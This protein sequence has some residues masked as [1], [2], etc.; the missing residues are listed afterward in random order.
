MMAASLRLGLRTGVTFGVT[1]IFLVL[2]GLNAVLAEMIG[3]LL[4]AKAVPGEGSVAGMVALLALLGLWSGARSAPRL[5]P[6]SWPRAL[7]GGLTAGLVA[8]LLYGVLLAILGWVQVSGIDLR[9]YLFQLSPANIRLA[10]LGLPPPGG[11][12]LSLGVLTAAGLAGAALAR[13]VVRG[14]IGRRS[15]AAWR[16]GRARWAESPLM[17]AAREDRRVR[18]ALQ[19]LCAS[20]L[21][22]PFFLGEYWNNTLGTVGIYMLMGLGLNIVVGLAGLLD[23][24]YVAFFAVGAYTVGLLTAPAPLGLEWNFW[25]VLPL[26]VATAALGGVLLG[27]PVLRLRGDYLA[28]VTLGFGEIIRV[29]VMSQLLAPWLGGPQG[30]RDIGGPALMGVSLIS[31]RAFTYLILLAIGLVILVTVRLQGSRLGRSWIAM[32]EDETVAQATGVN[33]YHTK[34]LAFAIGA[35]FAGLGGALFA[36]RNQYTGPEDHVLMVSINVLCLVIVGGMGSIPGI[37]VGAFVLKGLPE[38][39]RPLQDYRLLAFGAL[40]MAMMI[41]RPQGIWP[42]RRRKLE[43]KPDVPT[44]AGP[45]GGLADVAGGPAGGGGGR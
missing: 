18:W 4:G 45:P 29:L 13:G 16:A 27:I 14:A 28:I 21:V 40:L 37:V 42:S 2:I 17:V 34:L 26:A 8:G 39:L 3:R 15:A 30:I 9:K 24:G 1:L 7:V 11:L 22:L 33:V 44:G 25:L 10:L 23:L 32:R 36:A 35:A 6:D 38:I 12:V 5:D 19:A 31:Q 43:L 20:V 41:F